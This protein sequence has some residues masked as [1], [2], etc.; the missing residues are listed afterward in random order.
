MRLWLCGLLVAFSSYAADLGAPVTLDTLVQDLGGA[1][2]AARVTARQLLPRQSIEAVPKLLPLLANENAEVS[3]A[4]MRVLEDFAN[5]VGVAGREKDREKVT[6]V[7]MTLLSNDQPPEMKE[8]GLRLLPL[9]V[10]EGHEVSPMSALLRDADLREKAREALTLLDTHEARKALAGAL[11]E[12]DDAFRVAILDG[13]AAIKHPGNVK[14]AMAWAKGGAPEVR[15]AA[16]R[17]LAWTGDLKLLPLFQAIRAE[18]PETL[19]N[20]AEDVL[21]RLADAMARSGGKWEYAMRIYRDVLKTSGSIPIRGAAIAGL[22]RYGDDTAVADILAAAASHRDLEGP[23]L[24]ALRMQSGNASSQAMLEAYPSASESMRMAMLDVFGSKKDARFLPILNEAAKNPD[25]QVRRAA[26]AALSVSELPGAVEGL[27]ALAN[28]GAAEDKALAVDALVAMASAMSARGEREAAG[29]A[30]LGLY[31]AAATDELRAKALDGIKRFPVADSFDLLIQHLGKDDLAKLDAGILAGLIK[32]MHDA[33]RKDEAMK[34]VDE[35]FPRM[36]S[37][38]DL[39]KAVQFL[40]PI[41]GPEELTK[42][43]GVVHKW[44]IVG[45][46]AWTAAEAFSK[47]HINE[48]RIDLKASYTEGN[49]N[50]AWKP[51]ETADVLGIVDL[52]GAMGALSNVTA[53]A[54][55]RIHVDAV[56][57]AQVRC[58]S[59]DGIKVWINGAQVHENNVDRGTAPDSDR[60]PM[61]LRAGDNDVLVRIT[62]GGGGWNFCLRLCQPDGRTLAFT[63][64]EF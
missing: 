2:N 25:A 12:T 38:D 45:P 19:R 21:L 55:T 13:F 27:A 1:D 34:L 9:A 63:P 49:A 18:A 14:P 4:A 44:K 56:A 54:F 29:K 64:A 26:V 57:D 37:P 46:F 32:A 39:Q 6:E 33:G 40:T 47:T 20:Y 41:L 22:G 16:A 10:P 53:Y 30:Y 17:A 42:R 5:Q 23:A 28:T 58:G 51:A 35:L 31:R 24:N 43:L 48:P 15:V 8:K 11:K 59:D 50:L 62:Q 3:W 7:F 61:K 60:A 52:M 36:A